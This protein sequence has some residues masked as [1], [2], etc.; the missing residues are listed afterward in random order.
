M[1]KITKKKLFIYLRNN[2]SVEANWKPFTI[3]D[4]FDNFNKVLEDSVHNMYQ[5]SLPEFKKHLVNIEEIFKFYDL[6]D[7]VENE[8]INNLR[9]KLTSG[10]KLIDELEGEKNIVTTNIN[11]FKNKNNKE[12]KINKYCLNHL[13]DD[14]FSRKKEILKYYFFTAEQLEEDRKRK[15]EEKKAAEET[16]VALAAQVEKDLAAQVEKDLKAQ[17]QAQT[18]AEASSS[19]SE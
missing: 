10:K 2:M 12:Y 7:N 1:K 19:E 8:Q 5:V 6:L 17:E 4:L 16:R 14:E 3:E 18:L 15:Q 13:I 11:Y 9:E